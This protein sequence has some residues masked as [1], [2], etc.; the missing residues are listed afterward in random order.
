MK[1]NLPLVSWVLYDF[2]N[3]IFSMNVVTLTFSLWV[4]LNNGKSD[5]WV[6]AANV[7]S[8][9]LVVLAMPL[10][11]VWSDAYQRKQAYLRIATF[12]CCALT[13][14]MGVAA[15]C[16]PGT[17]GRVLAGTAFFVLAFFAYHAGMVFYNALLT[18]VSSE[19]TRGRVS[20]FGV[21]AG[22][23]GAIVGVLLV[24]PFEKGRLFSFPVPGLFGAWEPVAVT[25]G[26]DGS[27]RDGPVDRDVNFDYEVKGFEPAGG[28]KVRDVFD[29]AAQ[30]R[31]Y[32]VSWKGVPAGSEVRRRRSGWGRAGTFIPTGILC[33]LFALPCLLWVKEKPGPPG[34]AVGTRQAYAQ[35]W[36]SLRA[37]REHPGV[38]RF[39]VG[40]Y[41]YEDAISTVTIFMALYGAKVLKFPDESV[42]YFLVAAIA[43]ALAG[44][45][46]CGFLT[47]R[48]GPKKTLLAVLAG[49]IVFLS[50]AAV[51]TDAR[52]FYVLGPGLGALLGALWTSSRPLLV[53]L[54]P[55][56]RQGE[57]FALSELT[58][59]TSA[60]VGPILWGAIILLTAAL[61]YSEV[62]QYRCAIGS[63]VIQIVIGFVILRRVPDL[64]PE[65]GKG[66][67]R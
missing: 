31:F 53:T 1:R 11:G 12:A 35:V 54:V 62:N 3:T 36:K 58:G 45:L 13:A 46:A 17:G 16:V 26:V 5:L 55:P 49:W 4:T 6:G 34:K 39:L 67:V 23:A 52:Y 61:G 66:I 65:R 56:E 48:W 42:R 27:L 28:L 19:A 64:K 50:L 30:M 59:K 32:E 41:F 8:A 38:L 10:L 21:A 33:L 18:S 22:Y 29:R 15:L 51:N 47:D 40:K 43:F 44:S 24:L 60:V 57:F 9:V 20:G 37:T 2:A 7:A 25:P 63:L 14:L